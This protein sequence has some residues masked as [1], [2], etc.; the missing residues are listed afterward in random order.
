M[1]FLTAVIRVGLSSNSGVYCL[2]V[3]DN[4][5]GLPPG[6]DPGTTRTLGLKLVNFLAK[7]QLQTTPEINTSGGTEFIFRFGE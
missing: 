1:S 4:G 7:H 2:Q 5:V 3:S 6:M